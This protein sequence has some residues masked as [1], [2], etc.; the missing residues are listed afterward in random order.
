M[1][2]CS[3]EWGLR[4][5]VHV[6]VHIPVLVLVQALQAVHKDTHLGAQGPLKPNL[7]RY[8]VVVTAL[9]LSLSLGVSLCNKERL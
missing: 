1:G 5:R 9:C 3:D 2:Q 8:G 7:M 4:H 6:H